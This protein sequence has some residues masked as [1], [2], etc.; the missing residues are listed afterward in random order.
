MNGW[1]ICSHLAAFAAGALMWNFI[2][3]KEGAEMAAEPH[4]D[5]KVATKYL[6]RSVVYALLFAVFCM[7]LGVQQFFFQSAQN[8]LN[9]CTNDWADEMTDTFTVRSDATTDLDAAKNR[10]INAVFE[11]VGVFILLRQDPPE[12]NDS[13]IST[14]LTEFA[15]ARANLDRVN[16]DVDQARDKN[17]YPELE[18]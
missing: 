15:A 8:D 5:K 2:V 11:L 17:P 10:A 18:C 1:L 4:R 13:D 16:K 6:S 12:A 3:R 9:S 14:V 7:T